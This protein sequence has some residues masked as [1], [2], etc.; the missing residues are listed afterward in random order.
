LYSFFGFQENDGCHWSW[1]QL[2]LTRMR[3]VHKGAQIARQSVTA[4]EMSLPNTLT[5]TNGRNATVIVFE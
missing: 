5:M 3:H 2:F 1:L 4:V